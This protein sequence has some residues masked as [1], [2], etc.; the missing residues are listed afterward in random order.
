MQQQ[1]HQHIP[2]LL[3]QMADFHSGQWVRCTSTPLHWHNLYV[4]PVIQHQQAKQCLQCCYAGRTYYKR[5]LHTYPQDMYTTYMYYIRRTYRTY[6]IA[7]L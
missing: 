2:V 5:V 6:K 7:T 1:L 4:K 3:P